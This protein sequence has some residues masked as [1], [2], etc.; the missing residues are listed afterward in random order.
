MLTE[1]GKKND[2]QETL[3]DNKQLPILGTVT[4]QIAHLKRKVPGPVQKLVFQCI[5]QT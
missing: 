3:N 2:L 1:W 4:I 5:I